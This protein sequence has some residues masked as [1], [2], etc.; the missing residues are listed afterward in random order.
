MNKIK[1]LKCPIQLD[2]CRVGF[3]KKVELNVKIKDLETNKANIEWTL[4]GQ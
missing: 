2:T 3:N 1:L 4:R